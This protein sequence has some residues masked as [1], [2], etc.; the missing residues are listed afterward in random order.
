MRLADFQ[1]LVRTE[2]PVRLR[3]SRELSSARDCSAIGFLALLQGMENRSTAERTWDA[4][5]PVRRACEHAGV[6]ACI[7]CCW[8]TQK[9]A[10]A[11]LRRGHACER[12]GARRSKHAAHANPPLQAPGACAVTWPRG[13]GGHPAETPQVR[14]PC[15]RAGSRGSQH[16]LAHPACRAAEHPG[17][18]NGSAR[19]R[20]L[21]GG[22]ACERTLASRLVR[23]AGDPGRRVPETAAARPG[24]CSASRQAPGGRRHRPSSSRLPA[25]PPACL[26]Q[27]GARD[28]PPALRT[29]CCMRVGR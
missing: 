15:W 2:R 17:H 20:G 6:H 1:A 19:Q 29:G 14:A 9:A 13:L 12:V 3:H 28:R 10:A 11:T 26:R 22:Q 16:D 24:C 27:A 25:Q 23:S 21:Q 4:E 8:M 18:R 5:Q 7:H